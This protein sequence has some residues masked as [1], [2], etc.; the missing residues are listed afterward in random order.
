MPK[1]RRLA[2]FAL[3][4]CFLPQLLCGFGKNKVQYKNFD[5]H[6]L[7]SEHFDVYFYDGGGKLA[8]FAADVAE[9]SYVQIRRTLKWEIRERL[10][11]IVYNSHSDW[12]QTNVVNATFSEATKGITELAKNRIVV[13]FEGDYALFRH[14][15]HHELV[16][17]VMNDFLFD[18]S[19]QAL[20]ASE[21]YR[22]P[23]WFSEGLAEFLAVGWSSEIDMVIRD[24]VINNYMPDLPSLEYRLA[25][26]GGASVFRYIAATYGRDEITEMVH[27]LKGKV[28]FDKVLKS[29]LGVGTSSFTRNWHR[30]LHREYW[31]EIT[32]RK[33]PGEIARRMTYHQESR[34]YLNVS[35]TISPD[36]EW[37]AFIA[38]QKGYQNIYLMSS[39]SGRVLKTL[40][41]GARSENFEEF[42]ALRPGMSFSPD[43]RRLVFPAKSGAHDAIYVLDIESGKTDKF[44]LK[45]DGAYT[46]SWSP[47]G[48]RIAFIGNLR[49]RSGIY[50]LNLSD[51]SL[52]ALTDDMFSD[53]HPSWSPDGRRIA[54]ASARE[55]YLD[56]RL[57]PPDFRMSQFNY[58][59]RDIYVFDM[60]TRMIQR[61]TA[62]P[63]KE[64]HPIF[65]PDGKSLAFVSDRNGISN[66]YL[67]HLESGVEY[68]V[69]DIISG[70]YQI[71][72]DRRARKLVFTTFYEGGYDIYLLSYPLKMCAM[73]PAPTVYMEDMQAEALPAYAR[74]WQPVYGRPR[75]RAPQSAG[76]RDSPV[77]GVRNYVFRRGTAELTEIHPQKRI[78]LPAEQYLDARGNYKTHRYVPRFTPEQVS[79]RAGYHTFFGLAAYST[80]AYSDLLGDHRIM[81]NVNLVSKLKNT[82]LS[83]NYLNQRRRV[84]WGFGGFQRT[85]FFDNR[86]DNRQR[87][88]N[89][90]LNLLAGYPFS[91]FN[92]LALTLDWHNIDLRHFS[93]SGEDESVSTLVPT[94]SYLHDS[95]LLGATGPVDGSRYGIELT[96]SRQYRGQGLDFRTLGLDYRRYWMVNRDYNFAFRLSGAASFGK[97]PQR[98]FLGGLDNWINYKT[99][100]NLRTETIRDVYFSRFV[101][102]LRGVP[103]YQSEGDRYLLTNLEFRFPLIRFLRL[104]FPP[105]RLFNVRG[106]LFYDVGTAF[107]AGDSWYRN[108][109]WR[110][111]Y[112]NA[113]GNRAFRDIVSGYGAGARVYFLY[114]L[115]RVDVAWQFDLADSGRPVWYFSL[116]RD[117]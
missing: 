63:G 76:E 67:H 46:T 78:K 24:A 9:T 97:D 68:P 44:D 61:I 85:W 18:G 95:V 64:D 111:T 99:H 12:K 56:D 84:N 87:Y 19:L 10:V 66:I 53:D 90:G 28:L 30:Y 49:E 6:Y 101:T 72:W 43:S 38:D 26:Q 110:G 17:G 62:T 1:T 34:S 8:E 52:E 51:G 60:D 4:L 22:P 65:T 37:I 83:L 82:G 116:G 27:L 16:H 55:D 112:R 54:F 21:A 79:L 20:I 45:L 88:R 104:G 32:R 50:L 73:E 7:Q 36:G 86:G 100:G 80:F 117:L 96:L 48:E 42:H 89:Y 108:D 2:Y 102:P 39:A 23:R 31:P 29:G 41:K 98:F 103:F 92:R 77:G 107:D 15:I 14:A 25:Y 94:L 91:S 3:L 59:N 105:L 69:T 106:V 70:I 5:W 113:S 75:Y 13:K 57:V 114:F 33:E 93:G 47:D 115:L 58:E 109:R 35:P 81:F 40:V 11:I 71:N 74:D